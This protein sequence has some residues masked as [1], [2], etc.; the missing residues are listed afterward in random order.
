M[1][2]VTEMEK[3][4]P[5]EEINAQ[6]PCP[7]DSGK[8]YKDCCLKKG[9]TFGVFQYGPK[10]IVFDVDKTQRNIDELTS[11]LG[12]KIVLRYNAGTT[13]EVGKALAYLQNAY[14]MFEKSLKPFLQD[15]S[16]QKGCIICC[17]YFVDTTPIEAEMIRRYVEK[18]FDR[19]GKEEILSKIEAAK[20]YYL[21]P[22]PI[23]TEQDEN[24]TDAYQKH[25]IPCPF[26]SDEGA[27]RIYERRPLVCRTLL[28]FSDPHRCKSGNAAIYDAEYVSEVHAA[29][30]CLS[31]L[32]YRHNQFRRHLPDWFVHEF[33]F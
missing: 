9:V 4:N 7:C 33:S 31:V 23:L 11:F 25:L 28:V 5:F 22:V 26:L 30:E 8:K 10:K 17:H 27:C 29:I 14:D 20:R 13:L 18:E 12:E 6:D 32:A 24:V 2:G 19:P 15:S 16:C 21:D 1:F 3:E